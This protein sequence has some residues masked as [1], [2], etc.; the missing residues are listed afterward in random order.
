LTCFN[1]PLAED[2]SARLHNVEVRHFHGLCTHVAKQKGYQLRTRPTEDSYFTV[3]LPQAL[4]RASSTSSNKYDAIIVDEGQDFIDTYWHALE[5]LLADDG[6][7]YIFYDNNQNLY[8]G[9]MTFGGLITEPPFTLSQNCRNTRLIHQAVVKFHSNPQELY[10]PGP[11]GQS[12][13]LFVYKSDNE[14]REILTKLLN[15]FVNEEQIDCDD[16]VVLTPRG[17]ERSIFSPGT[18]LGNITLTANQTDRPNHVQVSTVHRFKGLERRVV[19][20]TEVDEK[21]PHKLDIVLY[22]G[23]SRARTHLVVLYNATTPP[24]I[25]ERLTKTTR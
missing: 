15:R 24:E 18:K 25:I 6:Y 17:N 11:D 16:I 13:E 12:P 23:C 8:E 9:S 20:L 22:V 21:S 19:I 5:S 7:L 3:E 10:C 1:A 14:E 2:L 4:I